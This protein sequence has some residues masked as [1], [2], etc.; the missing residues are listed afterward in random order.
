MLGRRR[1]RHAADKAAVMTCCKPS[2]SA[3]EDHEIL[4]TIALAGGK[5]QAPANH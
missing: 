5:C 4:V 3:N 1:S 2:V